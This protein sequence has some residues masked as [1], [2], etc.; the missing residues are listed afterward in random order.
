[1]PQ[2]SPMKMVSFRSQICYI[3]SVIACTGETACAFIQYTCTWNFNTYNKMCV[4]PLPF[5]QL[6]YSY[7][8]QP[9]R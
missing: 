2:E 7:S 3:C 9:S 4:K 6:P 5:A 8:L 1:M